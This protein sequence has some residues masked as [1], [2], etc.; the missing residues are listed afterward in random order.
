M[1]AMGGI[2][3]AGL[4]VG[5]G[6]VLAQVGPGA[7]LTYAVTGALIL[8]VMRM[9]GEM[10]AARPSVGSFTEY[11]RSALGDWAGFAMA[12]LYWYFWVVIVGF[13]AVAG[14]ERLLRSPGT[15]SPIPKATSSACSRPASTHSDGLRRQRGAA[16]GWR[17]Y[18]RR[19]RP[20]VA[21]EALS[22]SR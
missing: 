7:F 12:W 13:E 15:S 2:I 6:T 10:A 19:A 1:I 3:G 8:C 14:A 18:R 5:S 16:P 4:F 11:A 20:A 21:R 17:V 22:E 9:L